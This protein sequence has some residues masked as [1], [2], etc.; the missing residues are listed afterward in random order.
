MGVLADFEHEVTV[1]EM[2]L[3]RDHRV[4]M[5]RQLIEEYH[6]PV[7]C[8]MLNIPGPHKTGDDFARAFGYGVEKI[9]YKLTEQEMTVVKEIKEEAVTGYV[10]Y[11]SVESDALAIKK[12]MCDIEEENRI[13]RIFDIDV[14]R[15]D[16]S[17]VSREEFGMGPRKCL[18]CE[19]EA[20]ICARNRTHTVD[21]MVSEI[22]KIIEK[23]GIQEV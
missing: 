1:P 10:Y 6:N 12:A 21:S 20:H 11:L 22:H 4:E 18:M 2:L 16:G 9:R 23:T 19:E 7:I 5:Q 15:T 17:K 3:A 13:G 14:L 8:F